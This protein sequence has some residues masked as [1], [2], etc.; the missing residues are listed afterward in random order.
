MSFLKNILGCGG[1]H[2]YKKLFLL[3]SFDFQ[4]LSIFEVFFEGYRIIDDV[5]DYHTDEEKTGQGMQS[6]GCNRERLD[7][8]KYPRYRHHPEEEGIEKRD[9]AAFIQNTLGFLRY[10]RIVFTEQSMNLIKGNR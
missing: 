2:P 8:S 5:P 7:K 10:D 9:D 4:N 1:I 6:N 3:K